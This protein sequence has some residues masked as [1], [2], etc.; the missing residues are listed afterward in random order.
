LVEELRWKK[1][2]AS[3]RVGTI[4]QRSQVVA[5]VFVSVVLLLSSVL[6]Q[7]NSI[8]RTESKNE[9]AAADYPKLVEEYLL[10]LHSRHPNLAAASGIHAWDG[11]LEDYSPIAISN[12]ISAI[13]RYQARLEKVPPL[14]LSLSDVCDYQILALNMKARLL[15]LEQIKS[16]ERNPQVY[17][18]II[19]TGLL[20]ITI[21]PYTPP[22]SRIRHVIAKEKLVP[23]LLDSARDN[24]RAVPP[25]FLKVGL[26]SFKGTLAFIKTDLPKAFASVKEE[27]LQ[28]EFKKSTKMAAEA[29][30][31]YIKHLQGT[32]PDPSMSFAIGRQFYEAKLKY[33]EGIDVPVETLLRIGLRELAKAQDEFRKTAAR[34]DRSKD[35]K[36]VWASLQAD[37]PKAGALVD[38]AQ[39]QLSRLDR[40]IQS[41]PQYQ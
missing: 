13:K 5:S 20:Q 38:E 31:G 34:I 28:R 2:D 32:K 21:F 7:R 8:Q 6:A 24:I 11:Q 40:F 3:G 10:D 23:R 37:H 12:E 16:Y 27:K 18:D 15:E 29:I 4:R 22:D 30:T 17:S 36:T 25:I 39:K 35:P 19:S 14:E 26:E 33:D 1:P 41:H 9:M